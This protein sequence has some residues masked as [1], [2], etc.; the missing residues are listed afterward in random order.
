VSLGIFRGFPLLWK[1]DGD[2][3]HNDVAPSRACEGFYFFTWLNG[4][5]TSTQMLQECFL[6]DELQ[7]AQLGI[8]RVRMG[9]VRARLV[10]CMPEMKA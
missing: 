8:N 4:Q 3:W 10:A 1:R 2:A 7:V 5:R 6:I 9:T